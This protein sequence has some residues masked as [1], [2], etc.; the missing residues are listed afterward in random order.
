[1]NGKADRIRRTHA[2][3][4]SSQAL[5]GRELRSFRPFPASTEPSPLEHSLGEIALLPATG[6]PAPVF[7]ANPNRAE[8]VPDNQVPGMTIQARLMIGAPGDEFEQEADRVA[9]QVVRQIHEP[10]P[11]ASVREQAVQREEIQGKDHQVKSRPMSVNAPSSV[12]TRSAPPHLESSIHQAR[13]GGQPL[14][15]PI[16]VPMEQ[17]FGA[18]FSGVRIH[19]DA[20]SDELARSIQAE[21]FTTG[22]DVYFRQAAYEPRSRG[23]QELLAD[24]LNHV[25]QQ[26]P[27]DQKH[28]EDDQ[29]SAE[30]IPRDLVDQGGGGQPPPQAVRVKMERLFNTSFADV[31]VHV[32]HEASS[33]GA[34]AFTHGT[35]LYFAPGQYNPQS[36]QGQQLLGHELTHVVQ[37][38]AGRVRNPLGTGVAVVQ[39][40]ALEAEAERMGDAGGRRASGRGPGQDG[41]GRSCRSRRHR[42]GFPR[43][44]CR[45][46]QL[47]AHR[48]HGGGRQVGEVMVHARDKA[49]V[50]VT[51]LG[52]D[53]AHR[54]HG[55]GKM[56]LASA[57]AHGPAIRQVQGNPGG[58]GQRQ[59]APHAMVQGHGLHAN[60]REPVRLSAIGGVD[61]PCAFR[62]T[63]PRCG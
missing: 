3:A 61:C 44:S 39:D 52:V 62:D 18:D 63:N 54:E 19:A 42:C 29:S 58:A 34:L 40:P 56:L 21:A 37:Q 22:R 1:M 31:R 25:V 45:P 50:E 60:R 35:D 27:H 23:G 28:L 51:D 20:G 49:S 7:Q 5:K 16:R 43:R 13:G 57:V 48:R 33:I 2:S 59:R 26:L 4:E 10:E 15:N 32:G 47:P 38:R 55:I 14:P 24:E 9:T 6:G 11:R 53:P 30:S 8:I 46:P 12:I 17:A 41:I 36:T